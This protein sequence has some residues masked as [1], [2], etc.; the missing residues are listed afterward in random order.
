MRLLLPWISFTEK[1]NVKFEIS[2]PNNLH[3]QCLVDIAQ[4]LKTAPDGHIFAPMLLLR[5]FTNK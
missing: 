5:R 3:M 1:I 2:P 4:I